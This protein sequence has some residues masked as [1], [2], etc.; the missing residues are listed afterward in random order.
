MEL[1]R[2]ASS[3]AALCL[4]VYLPTR[5]A[6]P[7]IQQLSFASCIQILAPLHASRDEVDRGGPS[8]AQARSERWG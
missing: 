2:Y 1:V 5:D 7:G 8:Y 4:S 6:K 3:R